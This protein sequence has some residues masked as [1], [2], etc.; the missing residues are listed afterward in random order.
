MRSIRQ[1]IVASSFGTLTPEIGILADLASMG[2]N[3]RVKKY[4][5]SEAESESALSRMPLI[6]YSNPR[7]IAPGGIR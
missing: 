1:L 6:V 4:L 3:P 5:S 2:W 7:I